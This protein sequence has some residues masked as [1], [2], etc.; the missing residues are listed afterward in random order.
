MLI[1]EDNLNILS[2]KGVVISLGAGSRY[3]RRG[4]QLHAGLLPGTSVA[5][6]LMANKKEQTGDCLN[7]RKEIFPAILGRYIDV[8]RKKKKETSTL[9]WRST[10]KA[11]SPLWYRANRRI[12]LA[13]QPFTFFFSVC[14]SMPSML[15]T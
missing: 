9:G 6:Y 14:L 2:I 15:S 10:A 4:L 12:N 3:W 13:S 11:L 5:I 1:P 7:H 8:A